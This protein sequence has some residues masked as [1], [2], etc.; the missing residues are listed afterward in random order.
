MPTSDVIL[1]EKKNQKQNKTEKPE[2]NKTKNPKN[3]IAL[4]SQKYRFHCKYVHFR[5]D[6]VQ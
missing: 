5:A 6:R 1:I 4:F 2:Q 3:P